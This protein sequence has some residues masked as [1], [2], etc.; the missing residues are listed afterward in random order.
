MAA[1]GTSALQP[2]AQAVC[3]GIYKAFLFSQIKFYFL[4]N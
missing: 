4:H 1:F 3:G 2:C